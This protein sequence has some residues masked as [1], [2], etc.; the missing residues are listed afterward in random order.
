M[1]KL[2]YAQE[3]ADLEEILA[4]LRSRA[5]VLPPLA[6]KVGEELAEQI[7]Q[8]KA[9]KARQ[10]AYAAERMAVTEALNDAISH[11][12]AEAR[13]IRA[14]AVLL[15]GPKSGRLVQ[16]GIRIRRRPRRKTENPAAVEANPAGHGEV[17]STAARDAAWTAHAGRANVAAI[18]GEAG[19]I[20][21]AP[22]VLGETPLQ[23]G[24]RPRRLGISRLG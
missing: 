9:L 8:I 14:C 13:Y 19:R 22:L 15:Y 7:A 10:R 23:M 5:D 1:P 18:R 21:E 2:S 6:L 24:E 16:F 11:G 3:V 4:A 12:M 17:A 20:G